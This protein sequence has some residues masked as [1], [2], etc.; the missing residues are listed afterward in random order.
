[1]KA[2]ILGTGGDKLAFKEAEKK[3]G[4]NYYLYIRRFL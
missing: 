2:L 4:R 3:S 1:M